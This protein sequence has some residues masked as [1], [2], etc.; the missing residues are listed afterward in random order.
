MFGRKKPD[1]ASPPVQP[2]DPMA[3][4]QNV[5]DMLRRKEAG[6]PLERHQLAGHIVFDMMYRKLADIQGA[7]I[8]DMIAILAS[9]GGYACA[10]A[11][12]TDFQKANGTR[13]P[14]DFVFMRGDDGI[15]YLF[16]DVP[17]RY[18]FESEHAL[19][20][21]AMGAAAGL[22]ANLTV[23]DLYA[24]LKHVASSAGKPHFGIPRLPE[25]FMPFDTPVGMLTHLWFET[26]DALDLYEVDASKRPMAMGFALQEAIARGKDVLDPE[27]AAR[28]A[29]EYAVPT[30]KI[31][32]GQFEALSKLPNTGAKAGG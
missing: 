18:L 30:A 2:R 22:G 21:L 29:I 8:E 17:N 6:D 16:G 4:H 10:I 28:I 25:R 23:D 1:G 15:E 7:R 3:G 12:L 14:N 19:L 20:S 27:M 5:L 9:T 31:K 24:V 26:Q 32:P 11:A 13:A